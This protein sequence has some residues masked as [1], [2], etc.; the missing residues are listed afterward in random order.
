[1]GKYISE[2]TIRVIAITVPLSI[3]LAFG[4]RNGFDAYPDLRTII[5]TLL[6][7]LAGELGIK[8]MSK[9]VPQK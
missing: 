6:G 5:T 4:Y 1:M 7:F 8:M 9:T 3:C 2:S